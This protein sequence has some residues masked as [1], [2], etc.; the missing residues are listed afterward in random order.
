MPWCT[1]SSHSAALPA[2]GLSGPP[3]LGILGVSACWYCK[4]LK[5]MGLDGKHCHNSGMLQWCWSR[6]HIQAYAKELSQ[7]AAMILMTCWI[8][9]RAET[10]PCF[11][12]ANELAS[13]HNTEETHCPLV[14]T[15]ICQRPRVND[16]NYICLFL[17]QGR[18]KLQFWCHSKK[19][20]N[21][22][23]CWAS[24]SS[25]TLQDV[26]NK[27]VRPWHTVSLRQMILWPLLSP[28]PNGNKKEDSIIIFLVSI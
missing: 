8:F 12:T 7:R 9:C 27:A 21:W 25:P 1:H 26:W 4:E 18:K 24:F 10:T 6:Q 20:I 16:V 23:H 17:F 11:P 14:L 28:V 19:K 22:Q 13:A 3:G 15:N 5:K 2:A